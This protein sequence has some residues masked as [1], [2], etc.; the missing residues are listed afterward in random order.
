MCIFIIVIK[1]KLRLLRC[2]VQFKYGEWLL[3]LD[4]ESF[5]FPSTIEETKF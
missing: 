2:Y 5:I 3:R 4:S 1:L